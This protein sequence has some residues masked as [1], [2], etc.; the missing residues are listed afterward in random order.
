[1]STSTQSPET[2]GGAEL[3]GSKSRIGDGLFLGL[4][5]SAGLTILVTLFLVVVLILFR[6]VF[7]PYLLKRL[8]G[9]FVRAMHILLCMIPSLFSILVRARCYAPM[10]GIDFIETISSNPIVRFIHQQPILVQ[11]LNM[12]A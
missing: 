10:G 2:S 3:K 7:G 12:S 4:S 5:A 11:M 6:V 9:F 8:F 1:M